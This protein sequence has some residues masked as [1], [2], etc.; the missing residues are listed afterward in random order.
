MINIKYKFYTWLIEILTKYYPDKIVKDDYAEYSVI[1]PKLIW[2]YNNRSK[3]FWEMANRN[4][5]GFKKLQNIPTI[6]ISDDI[7]RELNRP[8]K[9]DIEIQRYLK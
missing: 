4:F 8:V 6:S 2:I 1:N 7:K 9:I 3:L 5:D